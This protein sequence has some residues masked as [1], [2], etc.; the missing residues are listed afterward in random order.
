MRSIAWSLRP[1][2]GIRLVF[3]LTGKTALV[4]GSTRGI[5]RDIAI[6]LAE[7]GA[8]VIVHGRNRQLGEDL[9]G[10]IGGHYLGGD[11]SKSEAVEELA[12]G[13]REIV[14]RLDA[15]VNNAGMETVMRVEN[16][17]LDEF[18]RVWA[19]N[20]RA[21]VLLTKLLLPLLKRSRAASIINV[22]SIHDRVPF[23]YDA[24]YSMSK[25]AL[26]MF[27]RTLML[28]LSP[29]GIRVNSLAPGAVETDLNRAQI[30]EIG[31]DTLAEWIPLGR[32]ASTEEMIGPAVF[33]AS[34]ASSYVTG[35]TIYAD[36]GYMHNV[37]RF[38]PNV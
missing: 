2:P 20:A 24:S 30:E 36:G 15:L 12:D 9:A 25:A 11:L 1:I 26:D 10:R 5:G 35:A 3:S 18:D 33:L 31:R 32:V 13:V 23:P 6:G 8:E 28:E 22:T 17:D 38:R 16:L 4:T 37:L 7:A 19:V 27:T 29:I 21:P 14:A 34:D